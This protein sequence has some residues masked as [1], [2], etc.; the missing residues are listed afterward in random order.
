MII[1]INLTKLIKIIL[2]WKLFVNWLVLKKIKMIYGL[3]MSFVVNPSVN[4]YF[5]LKAN[6]IKEKESMKF[7]KMSRSAKF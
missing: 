7:N 3:Y 2:D 4:I 5:K 1:K 6:S